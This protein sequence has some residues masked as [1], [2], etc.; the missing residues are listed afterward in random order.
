MKI[1]SALSNE[2]TLNVR[3]A[4]TWPVDPINII[5]MGDYDL[6][7]CLT[8]N[9]FE[10]DESR[11]A[12]K[13]LIDNWKF[14]NGK[15]TF[16]ISK[17]AK[18]SNGEAITSNDIFLNLSRIIKYSPTYG[19]AINDLIIF[20]KFI[21]QTPSKFEIQTIDGKP[22]ESLFQRLGSIFLSIIYLRDNMKINHKISAGPYYFDKFENGLLILVKNKFVNSTGPDK[23]IVDTLS[24]EF[25]I[26][27]F[28]NEKTFEDL[29][30]LTSMMKK[31]D[32]DKIINAKKPIWS[33]PH[34]RVS[35]IKPLQNKMVRNNRKILQYISQQF[36]KFE[37]S[38]LN[39]NVVKA[40]SLQPN[41]YPLFH[42]L[43]MKDEIKEY[44]PTSISILL[45]TSLSSTYHI[46]LLSPFFDKLNIKVHWK[47]AP[48]QEFIDILFSNKQQKYDFALF[49]FGVADP[50]PITWMGLV[51][52]KNM[53]NSN[54]DD[55]KRFE[56]A[57]KKLNKDEQQGILSAIL[58]DAFERG[59]YLPLFHFSTIVV[60]KKKINFKNIN[61]TDETINYSKLILQ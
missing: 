8:R 56:T 34:D 41:G 14:E 47:T 35:L 38:E 44:K 53:I 51:L 19:K 12:K 20:D 21:I 49:D 3:L 30:Q 16:E 54:D 43:S 61:S 40:E 52:N 28:V 18:W 39:L 32:S 33:R 60:G 11:I 58:N 48:K 36:I 23:I 50:E 57:S 5:T 59:S 10:Y 6:S 22:Q 15:Y 31:S 37:F 46:E 9:W 7:L 2:K 27:D 45:P 1:N 25:N 29:V 42:K 4:Y 13:G 17:D 55:L 24:N 26:D